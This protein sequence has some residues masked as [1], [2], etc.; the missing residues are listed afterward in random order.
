VPS[1]LD[2]R[3]A[4]RLLVCAP[5]V[6]AFRA[7]R[8]EVVTEDLAA[9]GCGF[10]SPF[11]LRRG[12]AVFLTIQLPGAPE[13]VSNAT[14]AWAAATPPYRTGVVFPRSGSQ[15]RARRVRAMVVADPALARRL[16]PLRPAAPLRLGRPPGRHAVFS[17][18]E[19]TVL[20]AARDRLAALELLRGAGRGGGVRRALAALR[21]RG[22][23]REGP[24]PEPDPAWAAVLAEDPASP[25]APERDPLPGPPGKEVRPGRA[26][27]Y[28]DVARAE[29][30]AGHLATA[31]EWLQQAAA[32]APDDPEIA[33]ALEGITLGLPDAP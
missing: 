8:W 22:L 30:A 29:R 10:F 11:P 26:Q 18:D 25:A 15:E 16:A 33:A 17:R 2:A 4:Q 21:G 24:G 9:G 31:V 14:V 3:E 19:R 27:A 20:R 13:L 7:G 5:A 1:P 23:V 28:L 6:L 12:E 32:A